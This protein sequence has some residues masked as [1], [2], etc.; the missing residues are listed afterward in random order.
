[1]PDLRS[2]SVGM[3]VYAVQ[4]KSVLVTPDL[5]LRLQSVKG[6]DASNFYDE[7][8]RHMSWV[9]VTPVQPPF[10]VSMASMIL[11]PSVY[12]WSGSSFVRIPSLGRSLDVLVVTVSD[13][14]RRAFFFFR[15]V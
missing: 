7:E 9:L 12:C 5:L 8:A 2:L 3:P 13:G 14:G 6:S 15:I 1:M 4:E 11:H 10:R